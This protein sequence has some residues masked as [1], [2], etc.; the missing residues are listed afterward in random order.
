MTWCPEPAG[1]EDSDEVPWRGVD[2]GP[3]VIAGFDYD[4][5]VAS[6]DV[7]DIDPT[8]VRICASGRYRFDYDDASEGLPP[9]KWLLQFWPDH[10]GTD[11]LY[12]RPRRMGGPPPFSLR[13]SSAWLTAMHAWRSAGWPALLGSIRSV[14]W[15]RVPLIREQRPLT[16]EELSVAG[17]TSGALPAHDAELLAPAF[18]TVDSW[19]SLI[20]AMNR[21]GLLAVVPTAD[22]PAFLPNPAPP[23]VWTVVDMDDSRAEHLKRRAQIQVYGTYVPDIEQL[24]RWSPAPFT[25]TPRMIAVRLALPVDDIVETLRL[26]DLTD[27][28]RVQ[29]DLDDLDLPITIA[30]PPDPANR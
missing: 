2:D 19:G 22:G 30:P 20:E 6:L 7:N 15:V 4:Q 24:V 18:G 8:R 12:R 27:P 17:D 14:H 9:E 25:A 29:G 21:V 5:P 10:D 13:F 16:A 3:V 26:V 11:E 1:Y 28:G 23:P